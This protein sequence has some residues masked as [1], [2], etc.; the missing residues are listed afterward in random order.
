MSSG[1]PFSCHL[2]VV[3]GLTP[4]VITEALY[5]LQ[6][7]EGCVVQ[8]ISVLTTPEGAEAVQNALMLTRDTPLERFCRDY[9]IVRRSIQFDRQ[10]I[11]RIWP[12]RSVGSSLEPASLDTLMSWLAE[13]CAPDK[14]PVTACVAGGRKDMAVLFSQIF[15]L[16]ARQEDR[17][18]HLFVPKIFENLAEFFYPPP[19]PVALTVHRSGGV[20]FLNSTEARVELM[21]IPLIRLRSMLDAETL[22][23]VVPLTVARQRV[24]HKLDELDLTVCLLLQSR[25]VIYRGHAVSLPPRE[26][27]LLLFFARA[28]QQGWG[29]KGWIAG[30]HLDDPD[31]L[32]NLEKAYRNVTAA[33]FFEKG[34]S[35]AT[36][37]R[38]GKV[39]F[40]DL[41]DKVVHAISKIKN[42]LGSTH[43]ARVQSRKGRGGQHY[44]LMLDPD[45]IVIEEG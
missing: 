28:R 22:A 20:T 29:D 17:L 32:L 34:D 42:R 39:M 7:Q 3:T 13:W 11:Y 26:F 25:S 4:Q 19:E 24:Q 41:K 43:P 18:V 2:V 12:S 27:S 10:D 16:L 15:S 45:Q 14:L 5:A 21:E 31:L 6:I 30:M 8:R 35:W 36:K 38:Q 9:G 44:G 33:E 23:G 40:Q 1:K 37:D